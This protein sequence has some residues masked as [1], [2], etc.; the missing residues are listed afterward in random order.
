[1]LA[2]WEAVNEEPIYLVTN[3]LDLKAAID[4]YRKR[5]HIEIFDSGHKSHGFH[6]HKSHV[7]DPAR[8]IAS[9]LAYV[10]L[11]LGVCALRDRLV[12]RFHREDRCDSSQFRLGLRLLVRCL[13]DDIPI[14]EGFL[15][16]VRL[17]HKPIRQILKQAA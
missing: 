17:P 7:S 3:L 13:K 8:L 5:A 9:C 14:T 1:M 6:I 16:P 11:V 2:L 10:W 15:V 4:L 12:K